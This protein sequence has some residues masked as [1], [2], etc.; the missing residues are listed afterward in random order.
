VSLPAI[1][2]TLRGR[3]RFVYV[4][5]CGPG[6]GGHRRCIE[7]PGAMTITTAT[8][9]AIYGLINVGDRGWAAP[10]SIAPAGTPLAAMPGS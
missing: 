4:Y 2:L 6:P 10:S 1:D 9:A 5:V 3:L 8:G 7:L